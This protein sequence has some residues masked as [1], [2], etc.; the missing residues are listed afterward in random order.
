MLLPNERFIL[1]QQRKNAAAPPIPSGLRG[2]TPGDYC[3]KFCHRSFCLLFYSI[4]RS[5]LLVNHLP[6]I[7]ASPAGNTATVR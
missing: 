3:P 7:G 2:R 4:N 6:Y 5:L 1:L